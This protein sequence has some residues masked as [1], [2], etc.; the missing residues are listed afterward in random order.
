[1]PSIK[2]GSIG[3]IQNNTNTYSAVISPAVNTNGGNNSMMS[4]TPVRVL[5]IILDNTHPRFKEYGN[6]IL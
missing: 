3:N 5:D 2:Y 1:M 4:I 6:Y